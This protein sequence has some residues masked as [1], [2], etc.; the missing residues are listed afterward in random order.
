[1]YPIKY[2]ALIKNLNKL[3]HEIKKKH[4]KAFKVD[5]SAPVVPTYG[6]YCKSNDRKMSA[7]EKLTSV[8]IA[9]VVITK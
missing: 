5:P 4:P 3:S 9:Y 1:M 7:E 6:Y 2:R 8:S